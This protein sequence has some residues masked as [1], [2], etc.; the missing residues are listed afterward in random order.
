MLWVLNTLKWSQS[1]QHTTFWGQR[2][3]NIELGYGSWLKL[4]K[5]KVM[6]Q[7]NKKNQR[8]WA[9]RLS[10][11]KSRRPL[12][13]NFKDCNQGNQRLYSFQNDKYNLTLNF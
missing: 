12:N 11:I 2:W 10:K 8:L 3:S 1:D 7:D 4:A 6:S 13:P 9:L 5:Y